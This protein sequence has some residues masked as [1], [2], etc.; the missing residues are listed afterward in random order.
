MTDQLHLIDAPE[1]GPAAVDLLAGS[2][3]VEWIYELVDGRSLRFV[4]TL[5]GVRNF[6]FENNV[7]AT[8]RSGGSCVWQGAEDIDWME[9]RL[10][11]HQ[12]ISH[13]GQSLQWTVGTFIVESPTRVLTDK[14]RGAQELQLFDAMYRLDV[15]T[16]TV[17]EWVAHKGSNIIGTVR[18]LLDRQGLKHAFEDS[19]E[20]FASQM[21]WE[22]GT[23]Y[24]RMVNDMLASANFTAVYADPQGVL[25]S[26]PARAATSR[27]VAWTFRDDSTAMRYAPEVTHNRDT[28]SIPNEVLLIARSDDPDTPPMSAS[29]RDTSSPY[30]TMRRRMVITKVEEVDAAS[31]AILKARADLRLKEVQRP[32]STFTFQHLPLPLEMSQVVR[33]VRTRHDVDV[34]AVI[35]KT[36]FDDGTGLAETTVR[37]V[38]S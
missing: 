2:R 27:G 29:A 13:R 17:S 11:A 14:T 33:F 8:I 5:R 10:R 26:G 37:E 9:H 36:N 21:S 24:L 30:G 6:R 35:E 16:S 18:H 7:H 22:A 4:R 25:R 38:V 31:Q 34:L 3:D 1:W 32:A 12:R 19:D 23:T 15:Q 28:Y 20:V